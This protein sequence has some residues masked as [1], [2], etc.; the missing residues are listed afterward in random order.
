MYTSVEKLPQVPYIHFNGRNWFKRIRKVLSIFIW[1]LFFCPVTRWDGAK[2]VLLTRILRIEWIA[3]VCWQGIAN[4]HVPQDH[5]LLQRKHTH[6]HKIEE[7]K[8]TLPPTNLT[9]QSRKISIDQTRACVH[10]RELNK[11]TSTRGQQSDTK[12]QFLN[13]R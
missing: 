7:W 4:D 5:I 3:M 9:M 11:R 8:N 6:K 13:L 2:A 10:W 1:V 12:A